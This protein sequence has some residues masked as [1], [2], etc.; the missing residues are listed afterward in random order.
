M[1]LVASV[2]IFKQYV[3]T[4]TITKGKAFR[5]ETKDQANLSS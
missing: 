2:H 5:I 4:L 1:E 3:F